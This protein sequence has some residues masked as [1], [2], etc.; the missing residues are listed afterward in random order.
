MYARSASKPIAENATPVEIWSSSAVPV[1]ASSLASIVS[2]PTLAVQ[3]AEDNEDII[4]NIFGEPEPI[5][6]ISLD[7][8]NKPVLI[9]V[10]EV[11]DV[12]EWNILFDHQIIYIKI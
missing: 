2:V 5:E 3:T 8:L 9:K 4:D 7:H 11:T 12:I 10:K 6:V 1:G